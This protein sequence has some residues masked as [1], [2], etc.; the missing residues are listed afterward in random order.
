ML[1]SPSPF[2]SRVSHQIQRHLLQSMPATRA[3]QQ[4]ASWRTHIGGGACAFSLTSRIT[5]R[6]GRTG[7]D[8]PGSRIVLY[9]GDPGPHRPGATAATFTGARP[10]AGTP[11][12]SMIP[13]WRPPPGPGSSGVRR[14]PPG[15]PAIPD[16]GPRARRHPGVPA[17]L[18]FTP[19]AVTL[20]QLHRQGDAPRAAGTTNEDA[21]APRQSRKTLLAAEADIL[22]AAGCE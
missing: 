18:P 11:A 21:S 22:S 6:G 3:I 12:C 17:G 2:G 13:A 19:C 4:C 9:P 15:S 5:Q 1:L 7:R 14:H 16:P 8:A 20:D 10:P